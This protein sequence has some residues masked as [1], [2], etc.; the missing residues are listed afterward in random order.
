MIGEASLSR[1]DYVGLS[2]S[3]VR[4]GLSER[5]AKAGFEDAD[6][7]AR[8]IVQMALGIDAA[9]YVLQENRKL[10]RKEAHNVG[11]IL[12]RRLSHEPLSRIEG[13]RGFYGRDFF[14]NSSVLDPRP[15]TEILIDVI[16][17]LAKSSG[18][19][20]WPHSILEVG[21]G[22]G[23]LLLTLL[24][25]FPFARG[26][27]TDISKAALEV[28][29]FNAHC[30]NVEERIFFKQHQSLDGI[31]ET[32]DLLVSNPPYIQSGHLSNL[33]AEV[34]NFDPYN[35]LDGG[36]DGL[37]VYREIA[38]KLTQVVPSGWAVFEVG[39]DQASA[40]ADLLQKA[41]KERMKRLFIREDFSGLA[42]CVA[43]QT[44][45]K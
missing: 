40:V 14:I 9:G 20:T 16:L 39:F 17:D 11:N 21:I 10:S 44:H 32:F 35:A 37:V 13:V 43:V 28:A 18:E 25:A 42:R 34:R 1:D 8:L 6:Y 41:L 36:E 30:Q 31:S 7:E 2:L 38:S 26:V 4:R 22:S 45:N 29:R 27:G 24:G 23:C 15:E 19:K 5:L 12:G 3:T 33:E